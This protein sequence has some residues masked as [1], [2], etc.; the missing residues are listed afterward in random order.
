MRQLR[1][2]RPPVILNVVKNLKKVSREAVEAETKSPLVILNAA[3]NL[4]PPEG[5]PLFLWETA[6]SEKGGPWVLR[7][8]IRRCVQNDKGGLGAEI[9]QR[10]FS[11]GIEGHACCNPIAEAGCYL[12]YS[13]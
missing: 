4:V 2:A 10:I 9:R 5:V 13:W 3:T 12:L 11:A 8:E 7:D 1:P 6:G